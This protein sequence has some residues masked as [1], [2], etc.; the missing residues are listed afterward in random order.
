M[1]KIKNLIYLFQVTRLMLCI[2][3]GYVSIKKKI[4][5]YLQSKVKLEFTIYKIKCIYHVAYENFFCTIRLLH[6]SEVL[7]IKKTQYQIIHIS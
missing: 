1:N 7:L 6:T 3:S 5:F 2:K 4:F